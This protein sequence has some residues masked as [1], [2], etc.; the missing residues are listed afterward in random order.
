MKPTRKSKP[1]KNELFSEMKTGLEEA[2]SFAQGHKVAGLRAH[3]PDEID[4]KAIRLRL[5]LSQEAFAERFGFK[6]SAL[7]DWEQKRRHPERSA[8]VLLRVIELEPKAVDRALRR[9]S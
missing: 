7:R 3:V 1:A 6:V 8:R 4:V 5:R 2:L 9:A